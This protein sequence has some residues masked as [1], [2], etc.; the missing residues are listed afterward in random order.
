MTKQIIRAYVAL[1]DNN[2]VIGYYSGGKLYDSYE[3]IPR[4]TGIFT[5]T[6]MELITDPVYQGGQLISLAAK[7]AAELK[8]AKLLTDIQFYTE[9]DAFY[10][11][12]YREELNGLDSIDWFR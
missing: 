3:D 10:R 8:K 5:T 7:R 2:V 4:K 1:D 6:E 11:A 9:Y 12:L